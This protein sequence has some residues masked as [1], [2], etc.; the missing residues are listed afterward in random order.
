MQRDRIFLSRKFLGKTDAKI[1]WVAQ[2]SKKGGT[3]KMVCV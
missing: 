2:S 3:E 1:P